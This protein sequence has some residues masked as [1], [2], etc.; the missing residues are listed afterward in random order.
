MSKIESNIAKEMAIGYIHGTVIN[1]QT[2]R[3]IKIGGSTYKNLLKEGIP[4]LDLKSNEISK[5]ILLEESFNP[6]SLEQLP[7]DIIRET[8]LRMDQ[9]SLQRLVGTS[10]IAKNIFYKDRTFLCEYLKYRPF[11]VLPVE[12]RR[13]EIVP[14]LNKSKKIMID[15]KDIFPLSS[16]LKKSKN[17]K[18]QLNPALL[19]EV[20]IPVYQEYPERYMNAQSDDY[21]YNPEDRNKSLDELLEELWPERGTEQKIG[22]DY[23]FFIEGETWPKNSGGQYLTFN[24]QFVD[25]RPGHQHEL[26]R[27]F[28]DELSNINIGDQQK[29]DRFNINQS[30][31]QKK[32][33]TDPEKRTNNNL[34]PIDRKHIIKWIL[35]YEYPHSEIANAYTDITKN[36]FS[37]LDIYDD[38]P[39]YIRLLYPYSFFKIGGYG[40]SDEEYPS[41]FINNA[42]PYHYLSDDTPLNLD[43]N[44]IVII[45]Q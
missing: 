25:P 17:T 14:D 23:P 1:T 43:E 5:E 13:T 44:G 16:Y 15:M 18:I 28:L 42:Y 33:T 12:D 8:M 34:E 29:L 11:N 31:A 39:S 41:A 32:I 2:G 27:I 10:R 7:V 37:N 22:G 19:R 6:Y 24:A 38:D 30:L 26:V 4:F 35:T 36:S 21:H 40:R 45:T 20:Y 9:E 3:R